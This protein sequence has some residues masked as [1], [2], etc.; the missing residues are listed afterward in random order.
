MAVVLASTIP[1]TVF[2]CGGR[3]RV[4]CN[5]P[6]VQRSNLLVYGDQGDFYYVF[7]IILLEEKK[8]FSCTKKF[9]ILN[10]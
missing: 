4:G 1:Y 2:V 7:C 6:I 8:N 5:A 9:S 3:G 10:L